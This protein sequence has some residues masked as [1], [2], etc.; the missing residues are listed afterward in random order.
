ML[1]LEII[2]KSAYFLIILLFV[3]LT[4]SPVALAGTSVLCSLVA[5]LVNTFPNRKLLNYNYWLQFQDILPNLLISLLM[6]CCVYAMN[7]LPIVSE[8]LMILQ[9]GV[10]IL[11][12]I[13]LSFILR[14]ENFFY[15]LNYIKNRK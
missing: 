7:K 9:I 1:I 8:C 5:T 10:G 6:G 2:K 4:N 15:L 11:S 13:A 12:Y 3:L 14:N